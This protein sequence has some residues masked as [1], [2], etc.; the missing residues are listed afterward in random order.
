MSSFAC[1]PSTPF[2]FM[3]A[4]SDDRHRAQPELEAVRMVLD[5]ELTLKPCS[6]ALTCGIPLILN[7]SGGSKD[8]F[9]GVA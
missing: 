2:A 8:S 4:D 1:K 5:I 3:L 7:P 9:T 6:L